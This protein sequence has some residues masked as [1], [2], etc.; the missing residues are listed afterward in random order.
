MK[1]SVF[2]LEFTSHCDAITSSSYMCLVY[3]P[4]LS[5]ATETFWTKFS[6]LVCINIIDYVFNRLFYTR[7]T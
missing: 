3:I 6:L 4:Y 7:N 1:P 5:N 2:T